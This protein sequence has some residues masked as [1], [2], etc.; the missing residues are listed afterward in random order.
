ME[1]RLTFFGQIDPESLAQYSIKGKYTEKIPEN[2]VFR[3]SDCRKKPSPMLDFFEPPNL[4][5]QIF[6]RKALRLV[7]FL[8]FGITD[9]WYNPGRHLPPLSPGQGTGC[10]LEA[11]IEYHW[12]RERS[13]YQFFPCI[14]SNK[15]LDMETKS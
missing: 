14:S 2:D 15:R 11:V 9:F 3:D 5:Y 7:F 1:M 8:A 4:L 13:R 10:Q 6:V 12:Q